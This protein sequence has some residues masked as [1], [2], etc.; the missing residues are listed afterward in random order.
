MQDIISFRGLD[1]LRT[2]S[3]NSNEMA[4]LADIDSK[5]MVKLTTKS[6]K[7]ASTLKKVTWLTSIYLPAS[8]VSVSAR[9]LQSPWQG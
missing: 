7:D 4:R 2:S 1:S 6:Q 3:E 9:S 8:F 5:N